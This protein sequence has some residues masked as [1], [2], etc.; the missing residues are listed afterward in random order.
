MV[1][2]TTPQREDEKEDRVIFNKFV[3]E[4]Q[5]PF[6]PFLPAVVDQQWSQT[7]P[8]HEPHQAEAASP[9]LTITQL[10]RNDIT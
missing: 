4:D 1:I 2:L 3:I 8:R 6:S 5:Q 7:D 10:D 9:A